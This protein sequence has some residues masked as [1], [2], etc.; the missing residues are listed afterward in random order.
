M[1]ST[2]FMRSKACNGHDVTPGSTPLCSLGWAPKRELIE[3][4]HSPSRGEVMHLGSPPSDPRHKQGTGGWP[5]WAPGMTSRLFEPSDQGKLNE[6][7]QWLLGFSSTMKPNRPY[8]ITP[9]L[10]WKS[11]A[12]KRVHQWRMQH[13]TFLVWFLRQINVE[14]G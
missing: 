7:T 5:G 11:C 4:S 2:E 14:F 6:R 10:L 3:R 12:S 1:R 13:A 9:L 8:W